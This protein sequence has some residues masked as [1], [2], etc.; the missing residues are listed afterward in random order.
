MTNLI[1]DKRTSEIII[2]LKSLEIKSKRFSEM[3]EANDFLIIKNFNEALTHSS[4]NNIVNYEKLEFFGDAVLR[5]AASNFIDKKYDFL[6]VGKRSALRSHI[7]SDEWLVKLG[8]KINIENAILRGPKSHGDEKSRDTIIGESTEALI[9]SIYKCFNSIQEVNIWLDDYWEQDSEEFL[10]APH[11]FNAKSA[12]QEWCQKKG[13]ELPVYKITEVSKKHGDPKKFLCEIYIEG[14][15]ES[16]SFGQSHKRAEKDAA[17]F[18][19]EKLIT[20]GK[21]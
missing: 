2:F 18:L 11:K 12:L 6:S 21:I 17:Y 4:K 7:V 9:G 10:K 3:L 20:E 16:C 8:E 1:N 19:I 15:K 14:C 5:L 13:L